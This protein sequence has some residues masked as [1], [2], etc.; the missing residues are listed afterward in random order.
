MTFVCSYMKAVKAGTV[1]T[2]DAKLVRA[3]KILAFAIADIVNKDT[4]EVVA[5]GRQTK[6]IG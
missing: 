4:G 6:F 5:Q 1:V 2:I 3:G